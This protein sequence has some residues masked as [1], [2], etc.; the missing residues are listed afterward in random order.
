MKDMNRF[1]LLAAA[2]IAAVA[3]TGCSNDPDLESKGPEDA[4]ANGTSFINVTLKVPSGIATR[5]DPDPSGTAEENS[6]KTAAVALFYGADEATAQLKGCVPFTIGNATSGNYSQKDIPIPDPVTNK[7]YALALVNYRPVFTVGSELENKLYDLSLQGGSSLQNK[8]LA[9][10]YTHILTLEGDVNIGSITATD[11]FYMAN[12]PLGSAQVS[13]SVPDGFDVTTL[14]E[15]KV[16]HYTQE[17]NNNLTPIHVERAVAKLTLTT[18]P[19]NH[20]FALN[21]IDESYG[22]AVLE[23]VGWVFQNANRKY[24]PVR[25]VSEWN[26]WAGFTSGSTRF[27]SDASASP[28]PVKWAVDPNYSSVGDNFGQEFF[29]V[30]N[31]ANL[32]DGDWNAVDASDYCLENTC[33]TSAMV[34]QTTKAIVKVKYINENTANGENLYTFKDKEQANKLVLYQDDTFKAWVAGILEIASGNKDYIILNTPTT[35]TKYNNA[36]A[37]KSLISVVTDN[38]SDPK[39]T[40]SINDTEA[41]A[42]LAKIEG[43]IDFYYQSAMFY[44]TTP[45]KHFAGLNLTDEQL[46]SP[47]DTDDAT[48]MGY[49]GMVRNSWYNLNIDKITSIGAINIEEATKNSYLNCSVSVLPWD[50]YQQ[51]VEL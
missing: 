10:I 32:Q 4:A 28:R 34:D 43:G 38:T 20:R 44:Y 21:T 24:Y 50:V 3:P 47:A 37:L 16:Y 18:T 45:V 27:F 29:I 17:A 33:H 19:V 39:K 26:T 35:G 7:V 2:F 25:N 51:D 12:A 36:T 48:K 15:C 14:A 40:R 46:A 5:V 30:E 8:T 42:I 6:I 22:E 49:Y 9:D 41:N 13:S 11:G 1:L 31:A 23:V